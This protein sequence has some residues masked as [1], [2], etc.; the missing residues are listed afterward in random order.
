L[1]TYTLQPCAQ[2]GILQY[3][4]EEAFSGFLSQR[5]TI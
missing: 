5:Y 4:T 2:A 3:P 1:N